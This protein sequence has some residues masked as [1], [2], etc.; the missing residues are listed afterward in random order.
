MLGEI[1]LAIRELM[2]A[3]L[4]NLELRECIDKCLR[5]HYE[6]TSQRVP[7]SLEEMSFND[8]VSILGFKGFWEEFK[9]AFGGVYSVVQTKLESLPRLRNEVFHFR[10]DLTVGDYDTL[11][12]VR[13]WLLKRIKKLEAGRKIDKSG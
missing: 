11:R 2:R 12:D 10:R 8:Y 9:D 3:S 5:K 6:E 4:N 1:E 7:L 13:D